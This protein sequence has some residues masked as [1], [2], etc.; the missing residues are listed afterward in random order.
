MSG[1][2]EKIGGFLEKKFTV[3]IG[4]GATVCLL[5]ANFAIAARLM[6]ISISWSDEI[7]KIIFIYVIYIGT[8]L[9]YRSDG[10]IG[11]TVVE[12][13][14]IGKGNN[15]PYKIM[16]I[17]Q[18]IITTGFALF[19]SYQGLTMVLSQLKNNEI[20][21]ALEISASISTIGFVIG[22]VI[23]SFYGLGKIAYYIKNKDFKKPEY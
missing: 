18:H 3:V 13:A 12:E 16:K 22:S 6:N 1:I 7:I 8:A 17:V 23:W 20:T 4:F 21:P 5:I 2:Y 10:L 14:L 11:I 9:A 19:C 15:M